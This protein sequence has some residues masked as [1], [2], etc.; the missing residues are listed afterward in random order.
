MYNTKL[1]QLK[2]LGY[3]PGSF[4]LS[5]TLARSGPMPPFRT[6]LLLLPALLVGAGGGGGVVWDGGVGLGW[7]PVWLALPGAG[8]IE[9]GDNVWG[10]APGLCPLSDGLMPAFISRRGRTAPP[11]KGIHHLTSPILLTN[12]TIYITT[13]KQFSNL[14]SLETWSTSLQSTLDSPTY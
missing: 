11:G 9:R 14:F 1:F 10:D 3:P 5:P 12:Y 2:D 7:V 4:L 6:A 13:Y 8:Q